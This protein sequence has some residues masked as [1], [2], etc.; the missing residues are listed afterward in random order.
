VLRRPTLL[1]LDES[2]AALDPEAEAGILERL[3][4]LESRPAGLV[5][6]H[7]ESTLAHCDSRLVIQHGTA[8]NGQEAR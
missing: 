5:I 8:R 3:K 2:T 4:G 6:A 7:R 1:I